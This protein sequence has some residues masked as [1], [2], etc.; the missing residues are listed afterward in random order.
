MKHGLTTTLTVLVFAAA[1]FARAEELSLTQLPL[2]D[3]KVQGEIKK[4]VGQ[5]LYD[6]IDGFADIQM[7]FAYIE[8][9]HVTLKKDKWEVEVSV[10]RTDTPANAFGLYSCL[11]DREGER[12]DLAD[13]AAYAYGTAVLWRGPYCVEVKDISEAEAPKDEVVAVCRVFSEAIKLHGERPELV[14][15]FPKEKMLDRTLMYFHYRHPFDRIYYTG[16]ENVL[17]LGTDVFQPTKTEATYA[18]Y[19]LSRGPQGILAL[20]Y[21]N[22]EQAAKALRLYTASVKDDTVSTKDEAPWHLLGLKNGKQTL[23]LQKDRLL[24]L[25]FETAEAQAVRPIM[26]T[27]AKALEPKRKA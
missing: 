15:A 8:S 27:I 16:T 9:E 7:G 12:L 5:K 6:L 3:W 11:R 10:F 14:R 23:A 17:L 2:K 20:R 26:E 21:E 19:E 13:E 22:A 1:L 18:E 24:V 4:V 25:T